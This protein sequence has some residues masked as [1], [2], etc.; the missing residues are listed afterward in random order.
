MAIPPLVQSAKRYYA[1]SLSTA[2]QKAYAAGA[3]RYV[4]FCSLYSLPP[5]PVSEITLSSFV[6]YLADQGLKHQTIKCYLSAIRCTQIAEGFAEPNIFSFPRL[7]AILRGVKRV[8]AESNPSAHQRLPITPDILTTIERLLPKD[9]AGR[10]IWAAC[11]T[12]FFGFL[13]TAEFTVPSSEQYD[14]AVHLSLADVAVDNHT[15]P[16]VVKIT[17]KQS[18]TDPFRQ[19]VDIFLGHTSSHIC[20][21]SALTTYIAERGP[22]PGP[23]FIFPHGTPLTRNHLVE[24]VKRCL[25]SAGL[26]DSAYNGHSFRIGAAT[27]AVARG[28]EDS[29]I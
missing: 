6:T 27:T 4:D 21:V 22:F 8:Q 23:L 28:L 14:S 20:P 7:V 26:D 18:K 16:S 15:T 1:K 2:S 11:L 13:R 5:F 10:M 25:R 9:R 29:L 19:G 17:I 3:K 12:G 24:V